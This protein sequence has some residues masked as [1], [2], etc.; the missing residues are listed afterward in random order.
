MMPDCLEKMVQTLEAHPDCGVCQCQLVI[1]DEKGDPYPAERQWNDYTLGG[2]DQNL[3]TKPN[4]RL[5]PHDGLL[6][7]AL[8][9]IYTSI[10]Q[11][12]IRREV[13]ERVGYFDSQWGSVGD[14]E[15][16]MRVGLLENCIYIPA[17]LATWRLHPSQA[18]QAVHTPKVRLKMIEMA[19]T[20]FDRAQSCAG[21]RLQN[22]QLADFLYF[23]E[24]DIVELENN[25][26]QG[27]RRKLAFLVRQLAQRPRLVF[28]LIWERRQK[29]RWN[30]WRSVVRHERLKCALRK[31][32]VPPPVFE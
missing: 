26:A 7:P 16:E 3:V 27:G 9:T 21:H 19:R 11:L 22:I 24:R 13:F 29:L 14:F 23:L 4:K 6:H 10:T 31:N 18:T 32:Q 8:F 17:K 1:I 5:A 15:W 25:A 12:L 20:A 28:D 2:Y 30:F